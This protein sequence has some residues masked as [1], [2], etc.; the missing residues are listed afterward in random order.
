MPSDRAEYHVYVP[1]AVLNDFT[2]EMRRMGVDRISS[3]R[4]MSEAEVEQYAAKENVSIGHHARRFNHVVQEGETL[5]SIAQNY[6]LSEESLLLWNTLSDKS[7]LQEGQ[8]LRLKAPTEAKRTK[9]VPHEVKRGESLK[10]LARRYDCQ[11]DDIMSLE[12]G[13]RANAHR[14]LEPDC[15]LKRPETSLLRRVDSPC[16]RYKL[17]E[18]SSICASTSTPVFASPSR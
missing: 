1:P 16:I 17:Q 6:L 9:W 13:S 2:R 11:V 10:G 14:H 7:E 8:I 5:T 15:G 3:G 18:P 4:S 12:S